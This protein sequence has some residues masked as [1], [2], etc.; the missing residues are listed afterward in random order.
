MEFG[1]WSPW[2]VF[3]LSYCII[4]AIAIGVY[5]NRKSKKSK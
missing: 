1:G 2:Q 5:N 4:T 3:T